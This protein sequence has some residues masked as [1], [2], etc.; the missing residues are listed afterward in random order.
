MEGFFMAQITLFAGNFA[1][2]N[3]MRCEGQLLAISQWD[4]LFALIGTTYGGDGQTT[5]GLPDFRGRIPVATGPGS[6]LSNFSLGEQGGAESQTITTNQMPAH[7]HTATAV[8]RAST[9]NATTNSPNGNAPANTNS[10][11][12]AAAPGNSSMGGVSTTV[13]NTG[14]ASPVSLG[15]PMLGL[16][17]L[18][19][20]VGIFPTQ[21]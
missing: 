17:F 18:I 4:A 7:S 3:W 11:Y 19:C 2:V 10:S 14:G 12:Y 21:N 1:P 5:F 16:N 9:G 13:Q 8:I 15:M 20:V 6:G